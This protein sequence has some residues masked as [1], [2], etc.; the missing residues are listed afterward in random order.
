MNPE[1]KNC[2]VLLGRRTQEVERPDELASDNQ[3]GYCSLEVI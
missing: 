3:L 2:S 1:L